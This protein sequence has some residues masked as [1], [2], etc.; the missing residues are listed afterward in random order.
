LTTIAYRDGVLA[1]DGRVSAG[2]TIVA[3]S[4][5]KVYRLKDGSLL[6]SAGSQED[7]ERLRIALEKGDA[8]PKL[9][10][11]FALRISTE[12]GIW[13]YE[14]SAWVHVNE[15]YTA[16]GSGSAHALTAMDCGLPAVEAVRMA[17]KRDPLSG[18]RVRTVVLK[19]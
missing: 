8:A 14:G 18:G 6:G 4:K 3:S 19:A 10:N 11:C 15:P 7:G 16:I 9:P 2:D 5:K 13:Y 17:I 1:G 12:S